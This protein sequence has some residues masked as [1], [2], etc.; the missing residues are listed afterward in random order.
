MSKRYDK[1]IKENLKEV[2]E[3]LI[4]IVLGIK[5]K[6]IIPLDTKLQIT[7]EREADFILRVKPVDGDPF[8]L[9]LEFQ[10]GNNSNMVYRMLRYFVYIHLTYK[11]PVRQYVIYI[12]RDRLTMKDRIKLPNMNYRYKLINMKEIPCKRFLKSENPEE[13]ILTILCDFRDRDVRLIIRE[14]LSRLKERV[15][16]DVRLL[17]YIRQL[18]IISQLRDLQEIIIKE[19]GKMAIVYDIEKDIRFKQGIEK[20]IEKGKKEDI[21]NLAKE[22]SLSAERIAEILKVDIEFVKA[23]I[24]EA[25]L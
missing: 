22:L 25:G 17:K 14:I 23:V 9:H 7:D 16:E 20:G 10:A 18:E 5:A 1:I 4:N 24:A 15:K 19:V 2:V 21:I 13:I 12:G 8:I 3:T 6:Q 11:L